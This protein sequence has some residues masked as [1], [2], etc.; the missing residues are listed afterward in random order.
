M[1]QN[2]SGNERGDELP[3]GVLCRVRS[4]L[5]RVIG[6]G[7]FIATVLVLLAGMTTSHGQTTPAAPVTSAG[8]AELE[9][10]CR[11]ELARQKQLHPEAHPAVATALTDLAVSLRDQGASLQQQQQ[12]QQYTE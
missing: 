1:S 10:R 8:R 2:S 5:R 9:Y 12:Q 6:S 7:F 4:Q 3:A 11:K